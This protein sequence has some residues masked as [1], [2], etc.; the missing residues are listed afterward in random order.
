MRSVL[1]ANGASPLTRAAFRDLDL[2]AE[3][4][5]MIVDE[6]GTVH[7]LDHAAHRLPEHPDTAYQARTARRDPA[8]S[9]TPTPCRRRRRA[10]EHR[11]V[12]CSDP[13]Q[14]ATW[15]RASLVL[16]PMRT[17]VLTGE[18]PL[19]DHSELLPL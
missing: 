18:A 15:S 10:P 6:T 17:H 14:R 19:H 12:S 3:L 13:I 2:P 16:V 8:A 4:L 1:H 7:R 5:E 11:D 9:R